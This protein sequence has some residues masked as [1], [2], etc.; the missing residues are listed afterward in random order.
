MLPLL[1]GVRWFLV[2][3]ALWALSKNIRFGSFYFVYLRLKQI[4]RQMLEVSLIATCGITP[5]ARGLFIFGIKC[6]AGHGAPF[7]GQVPGHMTAA[8][9]VP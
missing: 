6:C 1:A 7:F 8:K 9:A 5:G 3:L 2:C 4:G